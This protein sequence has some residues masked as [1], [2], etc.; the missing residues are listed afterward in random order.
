MEVANGALDAELGCEGVDQPLLVCIRGIYPADGLGLLSDQSFI[1]Y[2][3][4]LLPILL[5][6]LLVLIKLLVF[7]HLSTID[8]KF[9]II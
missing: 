1:P 7:V 5:V 3:L 2:A 4:R 6:L 8:K 9:I